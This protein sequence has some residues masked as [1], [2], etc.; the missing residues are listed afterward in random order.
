MYSSMV[1]KIA[2][3][4]SRIRGALQTCTGHYPKLPL[5]FPLTSGHKEE[6]LP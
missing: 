6:P 2:C 1:W 4:G 3:T 5:N